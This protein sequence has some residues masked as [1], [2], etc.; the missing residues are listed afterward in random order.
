MLLVINIGI[1]IIRNI[2]DK[3]INEHSKERTHPIKLRKMQ[4]M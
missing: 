3:F 2:Q 4:T 1:I